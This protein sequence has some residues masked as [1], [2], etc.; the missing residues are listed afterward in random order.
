MFG[1]IDMISFGPNL[2][3]VHSPDEKMSISSVER[4]W[5]YLLAVLK[6]MK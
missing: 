5:N 4:S 2:F 3:D 6:E 1:E